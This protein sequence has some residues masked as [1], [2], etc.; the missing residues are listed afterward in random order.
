LNSLTHKCTSSLKTLHEDMDDL[1]SLEIGASGE[2]K[3]PLGAQRESDANTTET[4]GRHVL[5]NSNKALSKGTED[6]PV[7]EQSELG[8]LSP[9]MPLAIHVF[10]RYPCVYNT[11]L[12]TWQPTKNVSVSY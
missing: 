2:L 11:S 10:V 3:D 6:G 9:L 8:C 4:R 5:E 1:S 7:G 12:Q